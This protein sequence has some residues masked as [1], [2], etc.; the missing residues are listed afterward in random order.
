MLSRSNAK[1]PK[2]PR[3]HFSSCTIIASLQDRVTWNEK[4]SGTPHR[5]AMVLSARV[6]ARFTDRSRQQSNA[7]S[8]RV[9]RSRR[10]HVTSNRR[11]SDVEEHTGVPALSH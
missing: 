4:K 8:R 2:S 1:F 11:E 9:P 3:F 6:V 10:K 5:D 7:R